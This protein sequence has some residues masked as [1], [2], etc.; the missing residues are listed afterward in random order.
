MNDKDR[1][2]DNDSDLVISEYGINDIV[3]NSIYGDT[4]SFKEVQE[5]VKVYMSGENIDN[6]EIQSKQKD[7]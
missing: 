6:Y 5:L 3:Y 2:N 4:K 1:V 7:D